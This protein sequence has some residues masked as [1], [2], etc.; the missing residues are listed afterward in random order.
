[1]ENQIQSN[2]LGSFVKNNRKFVKLKD[3]DVFM[4]IYKGYRIVP[5]RFDTEKETVQYKFQY[6]DSTGIVTWENGSTSV[7]EVMSSI[8]EGAMIQIKR[9]GS[10][11]KKTKYEI[12]ELG[13][14]DSING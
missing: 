4:A 7:A 5:S 6:S 9:T 8:K 1:M 14:T 10:D 11:A 13:D 2:S 3:G 12:K